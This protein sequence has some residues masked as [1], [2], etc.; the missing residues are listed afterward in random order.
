MRVNISFD[1][2]VNDLN[3]GAI[4]DLMDDWTH[5][6]RATRRLVP[7]SWRITYDVEDK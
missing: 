4:H 5:E 7:A 2:E 6:M 3:D 1:V